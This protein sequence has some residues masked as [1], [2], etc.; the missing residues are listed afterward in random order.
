MQALSQ[1][2]LL[3]PLGGS[4]HSDIL[5][6]AG[7]R[8][9]LPKARLPEGARRQRSEAQVG[10]EVDGWVV[11]WVHLEQKQ[12]G[13]ALSRELNGSLHQRPAD[14]SG[15]VVGIDGGIGQHEA[16]GEALHL[17]QAGIADD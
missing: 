5:L 17:A 16:A 2:P 14:A 3:V 7:A 9:S 4:A 15:P 12:A 6:T 8:R 11:V 10:V 1:G 13:G